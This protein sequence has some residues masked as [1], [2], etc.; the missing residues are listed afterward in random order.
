MY[1]VCNIAV[2]WDIMCS[3]LMYDRLLHNLTID[4][5]GSAWSVRKCFN[6]TCINYVRIIITQVWVRVEDEEEGEKK[7]R[8]QQME[9]TIPSHMEGEETHFLS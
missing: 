8:H 5:S 6:P 3:A 2:Q 7:S 4:L 9:P 1:Q